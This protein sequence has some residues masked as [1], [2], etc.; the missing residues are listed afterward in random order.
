MGRKKK[1]VDD[2]SVPVFPPPARTTTRIT[3]HITPELAEK[4]RD[5]A[6]WD[7]VTVNHLVQTALEEFV[8]KLEAERG[9]PYL[10]RSGVL[11]RGKP[12]L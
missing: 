2:A 8:S 9:K 12:L 6:W 3:Y 1:S 10:K 7:R 4:L 5:I 11:R